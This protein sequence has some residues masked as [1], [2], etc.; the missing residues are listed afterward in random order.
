MIVSALIQLSVDA[1]TLIL[2]AA[3][4]FFLGAEELKATVTKD[5]IHIVTAG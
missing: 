1:I 5:Y 3:I 4:H 2:A